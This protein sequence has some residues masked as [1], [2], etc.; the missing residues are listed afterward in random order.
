MLLEIPNP[1]K[2]D[3]QNASDPAIANHHWFPFLRYV[4]ECA[5]KGKKVSVNDWLIAKGSVK[6]YEKEAIERK[7]AKEKAEAE[8]KVQA[9]AKSQEAE[10]A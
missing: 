8:A 1:V 10:K 2:S 6:D 9:A 4:Q 5:S 3:P 7:E